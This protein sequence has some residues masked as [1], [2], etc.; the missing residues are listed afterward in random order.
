MSYHPN[1]TSSI[2]VQSF[3]YA[4]QLGF[5]LPHSLSPVPPAKY[6]FDVWAFTARGLHCL[7]PAKSCFSSMLPSSLPS[8]CASWLASL[9]LLLLHCLLA[10][11]SLPLGRDSLSISSPIFPPISPSS[12]FSHLPSNLLFYPL[13]YLLTRECDYEQHKPHSS[14]TRGYLEQF[15]RQPLPSRS[16]RRERSSQI[17]DGSQR[18]V[19]VFAIFALFAVAVNH[20]PPVQWTATA[21]AAGACSQPLSSCYNRS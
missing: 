8:V 15:H 14:G 10:S 11:Y 21:T 20:F 6:V 1:V 19:T 2:L 5:F 3:F 7:H 13:L 17:L 12:P 4:S 16:R 9:C 18:S